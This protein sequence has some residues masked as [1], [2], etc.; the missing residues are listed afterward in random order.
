MIELVLYSSTG[1]AHYYDVCFSV[2]RYGDI[3][4]DDIYPAYNKSKNRID[5]DRF[6]ELSR[7]LI[8]K[9]EYKILRSV[10]HDK[11]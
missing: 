9:N 4:I 10:N 8:E 1:N 3:T 2:D 11:G 7:K 5:P 6:P